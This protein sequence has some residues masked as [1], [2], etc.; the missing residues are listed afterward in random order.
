MSRSNCS[1]LTPPFCCKR[2]LSCSLDIETSSSELI[3]KLAVRVGLEGKVEVSRPRMQK[4]I[5]AIKAP[6]KRNNLMLRSTREMMIKMA[7]MVNVDKKQH[8][9]DKKG[10]K[11]M[12]IIMYY[13]FR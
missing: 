11:I 2:E 10:A 5:A 3:P 8:Q 13:C 4:Q 6:I 7:M 9:F 1:E 12:L